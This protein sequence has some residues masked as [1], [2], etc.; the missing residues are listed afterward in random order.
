MTVIADAT[1]R[2][3]CRKC[4]QTEFIRLRYDIKRNGDNQFYWWCT[5]CECSAVWGKAFI[6]HR[7]IKHWLETGR[8]K[9]DFW[10][11]GLNNDYTKEGEPCTVCGK[12]GTEWHHW[13]PQSLKDRFGKEWEKWP[14][15]FLC[16]EHHRLWHN[17]VTPYLPGYGATEQLVPDEEYEYDF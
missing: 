5:R 13:A 10:V 11:Q 14:T 4:N 15:A 2:P 1:T 12:L 9:P 3:V 8:L 6:P 17:I 7:T 16:K